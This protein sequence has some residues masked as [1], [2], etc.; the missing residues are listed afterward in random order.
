VEVLEN[1]RLFGESHTY[2]LPTVVGLTLKVAIVPAQIVWLGEALTAKK[3][4]TSASA[5]VNGL[6]HPKAFVVF[7]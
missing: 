1:A 6:T 3:F 4:S 5:L 2:I 7:T